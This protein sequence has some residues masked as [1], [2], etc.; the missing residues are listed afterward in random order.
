MLIIFASIIALAMYLTKEPPSINKH[1][2]IEVPLT[3]QPKPGTIESIRS[4]INGTKQDAK[5]LPFRRK[6]K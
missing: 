6:L 2:N 4:S 5:V 1:Q 3:N